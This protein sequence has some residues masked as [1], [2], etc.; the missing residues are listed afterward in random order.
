MACLFQWKF[1]VYETQVV[2]SSIIYWYMISDVFVKEM[3][4]CTAS[5]DL[6]M[7]HIH[8][9]TPVVRSRKALWEIHTIFCLMNMMLPRISA[10]WNIA[11]TA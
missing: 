11:D 1:H 2:S 6:F 10:G 4:D 7:F 3:Q 9:K 5:F 8:Y